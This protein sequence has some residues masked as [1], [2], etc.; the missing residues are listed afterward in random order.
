MERDIGVEKLAD[1]VH[2]H[3]KGADH[4]SGPTFTGISDPQTP[5]AA[6]LGKTASSQYIKQCNT[7][8][9]LIIFV[10]FKYDNAFFI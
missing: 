6:G 5:I 10:C 7:L 9:S 1:S 4:D 8:K 2:V 3:M